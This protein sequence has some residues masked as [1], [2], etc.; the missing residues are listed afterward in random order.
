[1]R[2]PDVARHQLYEETMKGENKTEDSHICTKRKVIRADNLNGSS[3]WWR[4]ISHT[5]AL[6]QVAVG[7]AA[8]GTDS[9][10]QAWCNRTSFVSLLSLLRPLC[11]CQIFFWTLFFPFF[12]YLVSPLDVGTT[13]L[14]FIGAVRKSE[15]VFE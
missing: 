4:A 5:V 10:P 1:M 15:Q 14:L 8:G 3:G 9:F 7:V 13:W 2:D 6:V 11:F 12:P